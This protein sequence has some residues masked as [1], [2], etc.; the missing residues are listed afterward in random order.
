MTSNHLTPKQDAAF[1]SSK[2]VSKVAFAKLKALD[3]IARLLNPLNDMPKKI[4]MDRRWDSH[5]D[6]VPLLILRLI[7][8]KT[9]DY[10]RCAVTRLLDYIC[11][12]WREV[13]GVKIVGF[14]AKRN[15]TETK[16]WRRKVL[17][18][19]SYQCTECGSKHNLHA[20]HIMPWSKYPSERLVLDNGITLCTPCHLEAHNGCWKSPL[21]AI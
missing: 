7:N 10:A 21:M 4:E 20:H 6:Y 19:D 15:S 18:R 2:L 1:S 3:N 17:E 13:V 14:S 12:E 9:P 8:P 16:A 11:P 5:K